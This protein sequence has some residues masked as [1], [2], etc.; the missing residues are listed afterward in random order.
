MRLFFEFKCPKGSHLS[1]FFLF[2]RRMDVQEIPEALSLLHFSA[3]C[4]LPE[5]S[6]KIEKQFRK[7]F[8][9]CGYCR[10]EYLAW[11]FEVILLFLSLRYG[12]DLG[13]SR[14]VSS[15]PSNENLKFLKNCRYDYYKIL[16]SYSTPKGGPVCA[17]TSKSY[18]WD[19]RNIAKLD[20]KWPKNSHFLHIFWFSQKLRFERTL[21][22]LSI[23]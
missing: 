22:S 16:H 19:V 4:D 14:L 17:M 20:Q 8:S 5:I 3:L 15:W 10:R 13:R 18:E 6:K 2:C 7:I 12:A 23:I 1:F 11:H 21:G 9:S